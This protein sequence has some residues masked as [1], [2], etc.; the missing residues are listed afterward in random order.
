MKNIKIDIINITTPKAYI[1]K[2]PK[3]S[4]DIPTTAGPNIAPTKA[5]L[6]HER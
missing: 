3:F 6:K 1:L 2:K 4:A 5:I